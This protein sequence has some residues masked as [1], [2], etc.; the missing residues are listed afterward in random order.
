MT[1]RALSGLGQEQ[2][3][4]ALVKVGDAAQIGQVL[5]NAAAGT[6]AIAKAAQALL[7]VAGPVAIGVGLAATAFAVL[8]AE[9]EKGK[10]AVQGYID[11]QKAEAV[12]RL[13]AAKELRT[14]TTEQIKER[15]KDLQDE[16]AINNE[17]LKLR[18][19]Q[20]DDTK[21]DLD[22]AIKNEDNLKIA[23]L[24][25]TFK[26]LDEDAARLTGESL[27]LKLEYIA[28]TVVLGPLIK[29]REQEA[30]AIRKTSEA[31]AAA[32]DLEGRTA[33]RTAQLI[34]TGT[35]TQ[36]KQKLSADKQDEKI[37]QNTL[38]SLAAELGPNHPAV[39]AA[40]KNLAEL[41]AEIKSLEAALPKVIASEKER[42]GPLG[43]LI[44]ETRELVGE[45]GEI[46]EARKKEI[47]FLEKTGEAVNAFAEETEALDAA[48]K[49]SAKREGQDFSIKR[50]RDQT[51]FARKQAEDDATH[52]RN[53]GKK[54]AA[55]NQEI[56]NDENEV[57]KERA[58][59]FEIANLEQIRAAED[60]ARAVKGIQNDIENSAANLD[61]I[62]VR[63]AKRRLSEAT[64]Q[65]GV[66]SRRR[67]EDSN[68]KVNDLVESAE[69]ERKLRLEAFKQELIDDDEQYATERQR[70][71][72]NF[73]QQLQREDEIARCGYSGR[74]KITLAGM[75]SGKR[76]SIGRLKT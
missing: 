69:D 56:A 48:R 49:L 24:G 21:R 58:K 72:D 40:R 53:R 70:D 28:T 20:R 44:D 54:I 8:N 33:L 16:I 71:Q 46:L 47:E 67:K 26:Q 17:Q 57:L 39:E 59:E 7:V 75:P 63:N 55:F 25:Q 5:Q 27:K 22:E 13:Q 10:G 6:G 66:K 74:P 36:I 62:G 76:H 60:Y 34:R 29:Q 19:K 64:E 30:E 73:R 43:N 3:G 31:R 18:S 11:G 32:L 50:L 52:Y 45:E 41:R 14:L 51:D 35:P 15:Q 65:Y 9:M 4:S 42:R 12:A 61:A 38:V 68:R 23:A 2:I 37:L 1:G